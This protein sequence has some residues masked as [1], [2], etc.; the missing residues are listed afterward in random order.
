MTTISASR[1][2]I[3]TRIH[4]LLLRDLGQGIDIEQMLQQ[5]RYERD[6]LLV[7]DACHGSELAALAQEYRRALPAPTGTQSPAG[8]TRQPI[9]WSRASTGFGV[10]RP[11]E[12]T[13]EPGTTPKAK[14]R[15]GAAARRLLSRWLQR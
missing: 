4:F 11:M 15:A 10:T 3:A 8:H 9:D 13:P 1:L 14:T 7:C 12:G 2:Q 5:P 6:V